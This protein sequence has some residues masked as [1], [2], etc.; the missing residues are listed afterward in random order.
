MGMCNFWIVSRTFCR[1]ALCPKWRFCGMQG[2]GLNGL[3]KGKILLKQ[4]FN[5]T[6]NLFEEFSAQIIE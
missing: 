2:N 1:E 3:E 6:A 4:N 5:K